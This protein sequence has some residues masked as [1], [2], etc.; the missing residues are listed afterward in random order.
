MSRILYAGKVFDG[1]KTNVTF[2]RNK[3]EYLMK[4][5]AVSVYGCKPDFCHGK[6]V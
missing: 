4:I 6:L 3:K 2:L 1:S 5:P